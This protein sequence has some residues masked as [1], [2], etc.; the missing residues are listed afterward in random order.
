MIDR[1][2]IA[3]RIAARPR[4]RA[5]YEQW[6]LHPGLES[7][8]YPGLLDHAVPVE[9]IEA[10]TVYRDR[11]E[12]A[13]EIERGIAV[14]EDRAWRLTAEGRQLASAVQEAVG[15]A[16]EE[17]W[18]SRPI[19]TM[20]GLDGLD[21][22][23]ELVGVLLEAPGVVGRPAFSGLRPV[24][25]PDGADAATVLTSRL[26][27]L[28]HHR[29]DAHRRAW[30]DAGLTAEEIQ[31]LGPGPRRDR[32]EAET[33]RLDQGIYE[34]LDENG[35]LELLAGLGALPDDLGPSRPV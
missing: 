27:V 35:R 29:A 34:A 15:A 21:R 9:A 23:N 20:P 19:A 31:S 6:E 10:A 12:P 7:D 30:R 14:I 1:V 18:A 8:Y 5:I 26:A 33:D 32:I 24:F 22:L 16:A 4:L 2:H 25:E 13:A 3:V 11:F 17:L 28:R